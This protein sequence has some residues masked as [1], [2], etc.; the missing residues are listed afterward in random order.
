MYVSTKRSN[1]P[2]PRVNGRI[3]L[4]SRAGGQRNRHRTWHAGLHNRSLAISLLTSWTLA[5]RARACCVRSTG[6]GERQ[7][8]MVVW[9]PRNR[10]DHG[11][12]AVDAVFLR[13]W[14]EWEAGLRAMCMAMGGFDL[15][16]VTDF[17][18]GATLS[19]MLLAS[20]RIWLHLKP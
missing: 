6:E 12:A 7:R 5:A 8:F 19:R 15:S 9:G 10:G 18:K 1:F 14:G 16:V 20:L 11:P 17:Q 2:G 13:E 3:Q 4:C